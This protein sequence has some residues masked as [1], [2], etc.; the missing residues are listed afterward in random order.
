MRLDYFTIKKTKVSPLRTAT[1][2]RKRNVDQKP[3]IKGPFNS[4]NGYQCILCGERLG[5]TAYYRSMNCHKSC[6][7]QHLKGLSY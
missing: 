7:L 4:F 5:H 3:R 6:K 1:A 2:A